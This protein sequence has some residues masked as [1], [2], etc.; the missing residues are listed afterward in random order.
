MKIKILQLVI[1]KRD[2]ETEIEKI[3]ED[4]KNTKCHLICTLKLAY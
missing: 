2:L 3:I 4:K 1:T